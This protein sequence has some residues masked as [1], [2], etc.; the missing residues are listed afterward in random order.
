MHI[1]ESASARALGEVTDDYETRDDK[2]HL[3]SYVNQL[4]ERGYRVQSKLGYKDRVNEIARLT[5]ESNA[6]MLIMGSHL[7]RGF[8][9]YLYGET[10]DKVR[11]KV[12]IPVLVVGRE[13]VL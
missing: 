12:K 2:A 8:M 1:V 13:N 5:T 6:D 3:E 9:D 10:V 7:H 11:H 4:R